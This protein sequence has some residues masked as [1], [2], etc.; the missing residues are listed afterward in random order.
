[1][2]L[3]ILRLGGSIGFI[4][5]IGS[6]ICNSFSC[7]S[8]TT[9]TTTTSTQFALNHQFRKF[10]NTFA[11][12]TVSGHSHHSG[13]I[14]DN[15]N[16]PMTFEDYDAMK[17]RRWINVDVE[18]QQNKDDS[19]IDININININVDTKNRHGD[20]D[21][22]DEKLRFSVMS[23]NLLLRHYMWPH[24][25]QSLPQ[26]YLDWDSY[27]FPLINKTIK[28]MNCDIMCF[29]EMEYFLYKKFWSKLFPTS[30]YESFFIQKSSINQSRSSEKIDGVGIF[31]NTKRFQVLDERKINFAKLVMK[32]Q[33]KFQF[34]KDFVSRLLPRNTVAIILKLHDKY[35][36]KIVYVT[37]THLYW[38][39]QFNDVKVLQTKL[40][41]AELKNYI[42]EN[43]KDA[44]VI[45]LGDLNSNFNSDVYR[46]LSEGLVDSTTAKSFSGKNYGLGNALIDHNGKIQSP[47]NL[48]SAYQTLKDTNMLN[49]T[50][51]APSFAD[52]LDHI[53]VSENIHVHKVISGVDNDYCKNLPVRGFPNDQ[54]PSDHIPIAAEVSYRY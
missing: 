25:Y 7:S 4:N 17:Y 12:K 44:S 21:A 50:S 19:N 5:S 37:N 52:V 34:T 23:Y 54:F 40:L 33:T 13:I 22:H 16:T 10:I 2:I 20:H 3:L 29:Q 32:H 28:Q 45:F 39:P 15:T 51:F 47:F 42:K 26:E 43:Y 31:I 11:F 38:S 35:T 30:E 8:I 48:S 53:F 36:D 6:S 9:T 1:M 18:K 49:F 46:L 41:L 14:V 27:R 24:V